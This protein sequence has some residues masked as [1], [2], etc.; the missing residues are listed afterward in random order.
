MTYG[1]KEN[2]NR[3][4]SYWQCRLIG[5]FDRSGTTDTCNPI[6][7]TIITPPVYQIFTI[8]QLKSCSHQLQQ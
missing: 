1:N 2:Q 5:T 4:Y 7:V 3:Q 8:R 6:V